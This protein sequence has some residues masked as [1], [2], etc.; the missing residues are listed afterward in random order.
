MKGLRDFTDFKL[1]PACGKRIKRLGGRGHW[2]MFLRHRTTGERRTRKV[3]YGLCVRCACKFHAGGEA[4]RIRVARIERMIGVP[5][6]A[7]GD[8][9]ILPTRLQ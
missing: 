3:P 1:C 5:I 8:W 7:E 2:L 4:L 9:E 6:E